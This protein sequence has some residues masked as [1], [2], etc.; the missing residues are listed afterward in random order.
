MLKEILIAISG[1]LLVASLV[2]HVFIRAKLKP[3]A[4]DL[5]D[6]YHEFEDDHPKVLK[7]EKYSKIASGITAVSLL[8]LFAC[9]V[10]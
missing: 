6:Y 8:I 1:F 3:Q 10:L 7:Y 4:D 9:A 2:A 5:D